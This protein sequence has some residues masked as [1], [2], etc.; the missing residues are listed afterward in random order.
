[1]AK[2]GFAYEP[3]AP[4]ERA[5][6][7]S[8]RANTALRDYALMGPG[9]SLRKLYEKYRDQIAIRSRSK[10]QGILHSNLPGEPPTSRL[11][12]LLTWSADFGWQERV[13]IWERL[14]DALDE[15]LWIERRRQARE[16]EWE[17]GSNLLDLFR[18]AM[19]EAP[20]F[21]QTT[22]RVTKD[23]RE[24]IT[25]ALDLPSV[26]KSAEAGTKLRRLASGMET[27][28]QRVEHEGLIRKPDDF[29]EMDDDEL[30]HLILNLSA[31]ADPGE[32]GAGA[33]RETAPE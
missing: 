5:K 22:R 8:L 17:N 23:G 10:I 9:R 26:I 14:Q 16:E 27:D 31:A 30:D 28:R 12:T 13:A 24:I 32:T 2:Q 1:V 33:D 11:G 19:A 6:G 7:E 25:V 4:L 18:N 3:E 15:I 20:K 21:L 29:T